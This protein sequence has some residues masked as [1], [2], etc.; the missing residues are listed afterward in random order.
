MTIVKFSHQIESSNLG[1]DDV[2]DLFKLTLDR[3]LT[4][5]V[6]GFADDWDD[7]VPSNTENSSPLPFKLHNYFIRV[8]TNRPCI[9]WS[10]D[11]EQYYMVKTGGSNDTSFNQLNISNRTIKK[12]TLTEEGRTWASLGSTF[13]K[14][15][16]RKSRNGRM[17]TERVGSPRT[18]N[19]KQFKLQLKNVD[20][21]TTPLDC[22]YYAIITGTLEYDAQ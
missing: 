1:K 4:A 14:Y 9:L 20:P 17:Y 3:T 6:G 7:A 21:S 11:V 13:V 2:D 5:G 10:S 18:Y 22:A 15:K 16:K 19:N 8:W 12:W